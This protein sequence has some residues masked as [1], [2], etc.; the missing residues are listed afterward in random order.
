RR[1]EMVN[2][3]RNIPTVNRDVIELFIAEQQMFNELNPSPW[4][5]DERVRYNNDGKF[6]D[7]RCESDLADIFTLFST[8]EYQHNPN[9]NEY[10][11]TIERRR[12]RRVEV[13]MFQQQVDDWKSEHFAK[14]VNRSVI[15]LFEY[16]QLNPE[17]PR[18]ELI[19]FVPFL[20]RDDFEHGACD[21]Y[22]VYTVYNRHTGGVA[23]RW[24]WQEF[25]LIWRRDFD[26]VLLP[27]RQRDRGWEFSRWIMGLEFVTLT[28]RNAA[29]RDRIPTDRQLPGVSPSELR[30]VG[31][32]ANDSSDDEGIRDITRGIRNL[33][34][35]YG[36]RNNRNN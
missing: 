14:W 17:S 29:Y 35:P 18:H 11:Y 25:Q 28:R 26:A 36:R 16:Y 30:V 21:E 24:S 13:V 7:C 5:S 27:P 4:L 31:R 12:D 1:N 15:A 9:Y 22:G 3:D 20:N 6:I 23:A 19:F 33:V 34:H 2:Y 32:R 8:A 10:Y